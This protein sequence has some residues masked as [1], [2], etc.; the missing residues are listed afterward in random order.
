MP[1]SVSSASPETAQITTASL[2]AGARIFHDF[3]PFRN[4]AR[5]VVGE[6]PR[7][8]RGD[9]RAER[10]EPLAQVG[11]AQHLDDVAVEPLDERRGRGR[12]HDDAVPGDRLEPRYA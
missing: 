7:R 4:L 11:Q 9:F 1:S 5:D 3:R 10:L 6:I 12:G 8:A 2:G